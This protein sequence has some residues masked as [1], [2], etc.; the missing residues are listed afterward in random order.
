MNTP[1]TAGGLA[2][3]IAIL[4]W[5]GLRWWQ[6]QKTQKTKD[7]RSLTPFGSGIALGILAAACTGGLLGT[8]SGWVRG[9]SN[10]VGDKALA[11]A[12]G[13]GGQAIG[14]STFPALSVGGALI[15]VGAFVALFALWKKIKEDRHKPIIFGAV[16]GS[17]LGTSAGAAG[18]LALAVIPLVNSVGDSILG[19]I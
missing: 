18:T 9:A 3:G 15:A 7:W 6:S 17:T 1:I 13:A 11:G 12:T 2:V 19:V 5:Y 8:V 10:G 16:C 14:A 4:V